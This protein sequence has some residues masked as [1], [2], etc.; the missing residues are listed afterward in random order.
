M[1]IFNSNG[2]LHGSF[3]SLPNEGY[4][5]TTLWTVAE[6]P[7]GETFD[8]RY[9]YT[10]VDGIAIKGDLIPVDTVE[11]NRLEAEVIA[12][13]YSRDRKAK[14]DLLNQ[15]EM[16]YDDVKNSTTTWVDAIDAIKSAH[17]KP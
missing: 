11:V 13:Q 2:D 6:F 4:L 7:E 5:D 17:P 15:D 3:S 8:P 14:Y 12:T 10:S 16:R 9:S 1:I